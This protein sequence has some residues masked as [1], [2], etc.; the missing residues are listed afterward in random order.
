[1]TTRSSPFR[2]R[3]RR[4]SNRP[5]LANRWTS[6]SNLFV[7]VSPAGRE[8]AERQTNAQLLRAIRSAR[9]ELSQA[10]RMTIE[11]GGD[12]SVRVRFERDVSCGA[13]RKQLPAPPVALLFIP[14]A[15]K[16][17]TLRSGGEAG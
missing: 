4:Y 13:G 16:P 3:P 5:C 17:R 15:R 14:G 7:D 1:M 8:R 12:F 2:E 6:R 10:D 11:A 9:A